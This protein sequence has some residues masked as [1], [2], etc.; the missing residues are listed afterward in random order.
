MKK[1]V[2]ILLAVFALV[3]C[4]NQQQ[5]D[6]TKLENKLSEIICTDSV[7][8]ISVAYI[9]PNDTSFSAEI[10]NPQF[11]TQAETDSLRM[12]SGESV[13]QAASLSKVVFAYIVNKMA[14][15]GEINL[16]TPVK[17]YTDME[18][19]VKKGGNYG[20]FT[21]EESIKMAE[22]L[23]PRIILS[24]RTGLP[25]WSAS[26]SSDAWPTSHITFKFPAD[27]CYGYSG[28]GFALLQRAVE[29]IK[30]KDIQAIAQEEVFGPLGMR[31]TSYAWEDKYDTLAL[32]GYNRNCENRGKGRHPRANVGYT[33]RTTA[34]DYIKFVNLLMQGV[35][36]NDAAVIAMT[37]IA[38]DAPKAIRYA[39]EPRECD[40]TMYW[41]LGVGLEQHPVYGKTIWHWGN[42]GNF[43]ALF[44][45]VP[46]ENKCFVYFTNGARGHD[47]VNKITSEFIGGTFA[48][49]RWINS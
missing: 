23:T 15:R 11:Y 1:L 7:P 35:K 28:E 5:K 21:E 20:R 29:A 22:K 34:N 38:P 48:I 10:F 8:A 9:A 18:R 3:S 13:F 33:L 31:N 16:D 49:E 40:S 24:H 30:G 36:N 27:S 46:D 32:D 37:N 12:H 26:P 44:M 19:F 17:E 43:R 41:G 47:I 39:N 45:I 4:N 6:Y 25:N 14:Q 42:N 2:Y